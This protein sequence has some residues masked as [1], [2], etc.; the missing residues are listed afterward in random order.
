M[1][2]TE[3]L[4]GGQTEIVISEGSVPGA[5]GDPGTPGPPGPGVVVIESDQTAPPAGTVANTL[6]FRK[7]Q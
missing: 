3:L 6:V 1:T 2:S 4:N 7:R 5:K